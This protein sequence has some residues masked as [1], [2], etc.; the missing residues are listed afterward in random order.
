MASKARCVLAHRDSTRSLISER[1]SH[2]QARVKRALAL[3][4]A[5]ERGLITTASV[6]VPESSRVAGR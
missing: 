3:L 2:Y 6:V 1:C 5:V 4:E